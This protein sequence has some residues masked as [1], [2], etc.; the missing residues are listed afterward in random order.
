[1]KTLKEIEQKGYHGTDQI[2]FRFLCRKDNGKCISPRAFSQGPKS[3]L[4]ST[5]SMVVFFYLDGRAYSTPII[6]SKRRKIEWIIKE[7]FK[8]C[9]G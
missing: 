9:L 2:Q 4:L 7:T 1:M 3:A 5:S 6:E 8:I